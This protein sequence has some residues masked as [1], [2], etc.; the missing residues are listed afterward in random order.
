M[1]TPLS[2]FLEKYEKDEFVRAHMPGHK[3]KGEIEKYDITEVEGADVL[4]SAK[5]VILESEEN[6]SALFGSKK[7]LYSA[8]G[9]SLSIRAMLYLTKL[10]AL[11]QNK[12]CK[13]LA[14]RNAHKV[15]ITASALLDIDV[16]WVFSDESRGLTVCKITP[17]SLEKALLECEEKPVA[18]YITS[19]DYLGNI[20]D[21]KGLSEVC[22]RH[23]VLLLVDNAHG[24]YLRFL[25][26][27]L[28]PMDLGADLCCDS[29]HKTL[30]ALT[31]A[32]YL[33]IGKNAP[34][35]FCENAQKAMSLFSSTSPSY[36]I[37]RSLD[38]VNGYISEGFEKR[39]L[40]FSEKIRKLK[41]TLIE[42]GFELCGDEP[43]KITAYAKAYGY[44]GEEIANELLKNG[45]SC[46]FSDMDYVCLMLT[47]S[48]TE[49]EILKIEK[50]F[51]QIERK[52]PIKEK[53][54]IMNKPKKYCS[55][56]EAAFSLFQRLPLEQ[57]EG[58]VL[59]N[60]TVSCPPAVPVLVSGEVI[61]KDAIKVMRY[62]GLQYADVIN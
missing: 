57:C 21:I 24:A 52:T 38:R 23:G 29:A 15:F 27:S 32:A 34:P 50:A 33:H 10:Y 47:P 51:L 39:L 22:K 28:H 42:K 2:D 3:G 44:T 35:L 11:S 31:G 36:L 1:N 53:P 6:A 58:R 8:E 56:K 13:I 55:P 25:P 12:R 54:P 30:P 9:S 5:G 45:I 40:E 17:K 48:N 41:D 37:L 61:D 62:Y 26:E 7:T 19:P 16:S 4:Y 14:G 20:T 49:K 59:A 46:E 60:V 43:L 18:V